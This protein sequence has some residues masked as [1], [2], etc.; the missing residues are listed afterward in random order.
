MA[1][2]LN[3]V[4]LPQRRAGKNQHGQPV[5]TVMKLGI[6]TRLHYVYPYPHVD[7]ASH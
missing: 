2:M 1:L 3:I 4:W 5:R 7:D 6:W